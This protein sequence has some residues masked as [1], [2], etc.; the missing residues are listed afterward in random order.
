MFEPDC[1]KDQQFSKLEYFSR[2]LVHFFIKTF[3][4]EGEHR[5]YQN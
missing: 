5:G 2:V 3:V 1:W 4:P